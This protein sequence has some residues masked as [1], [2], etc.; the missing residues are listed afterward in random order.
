MTENAQNRPRIFSPSSIQ[1]RPEW[2]RRGG[3]TR[4]T[5]QLVLC[6]HEDSSYRAL[7]DHH[8]P[9][10]R[11]HYGTNASSNTRHPGDRGRSG[12]RSAIRSTNNRTNLDTLCNRHA[13]AYADP[14]RD[15]GAYADPNPDAP[16]HTRS[17]RPTLDRETAVCRRPDKKAGAIVRISKGVEKGAV[18]GILQ[19][20]LAIGAA[21]QKPFNRP[22]SWRECEGVE[23]TQEREAAPATVLKG[24]NPGSALPRTISIHSQSIR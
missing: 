10:R 17:T 18:D 20:A 2:Y 1:E 3:S 12:C 7:G 21:S 8:G 16:R 23:P 22:S 14:N 4:A 6:P 19:V 11:L 13:G 15:A 5:I 24:G 9:C